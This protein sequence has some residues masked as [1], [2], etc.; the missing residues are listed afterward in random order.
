MSD[1]DKE[2]QAPSHQT[3]AA[4]K[5][6]LS[7]TVGLGGS[8]PMTATRTPLGPASLVFPA[9]DPD[10]DRDVL[11]SDGKTIRKKRSALIYPSASLAA[12]SNQQPFSRSAA[13]RES[14]LALGSIGYLQH[15][16]TK[17]GIANRNRPVAKGMMALAIGPAG[18]A[19]LANKA[20]TA[21]GSTSPPDPIRHARSTSAS[22]QI[23][24]D[25][26]E[27]ENFELPPSPTA[28]TYARPKYLDVARPLEA[29]TKALRALLIADLHQLC[30]AWALWDWISHDPTVASIKLLL[31]EGQPTPSSS[32]VAEESA[33][34]EVPAIIAVTTKAIRS[35]RSYVLALPQRSTVPATAPNQPNGRDMYRRQ[36]GFSG[37]CRPGQTGTPVTTRTSEFSHNGPTARDASAQQASRS[38]ALSQSLPGGPASNVRAQDDTEHLSILRKAALEILSALKAMEERHRAELEDER[39]QQDGAASICPAREEDQHPSSSNDAEESSAVDTASE[40]GYSYRP[41]LQLSDLATERKLLQGY[42]KTVSSILTSSNTGIQE[43]KKDCRRLSNSTST[44]ANDNRK[45]TEDVQRTTAAVDSTLLNSGERPA[46][47]ADIGRRWTKINLCTAQRILSFVVDHC[48]SCVGQDFSE[49]RL[50]RLHDAGDDLDRLLVLLHDGYL[51]CRALNEVVRRSDR[52]W[53]YI[54]SSEIHDLEAEEAALRQKEALRVRQEQESDAPKFQTRTSSRT[55]SEGDSVTA[56]VGG[57]SNPSES[58]IFNGRPGWTFRRTENLRVWAAALKLRYQIQTTATKAFASKPTSTDPTYGSLGLGKLA[59]HGRRVASESHAST[60]S[61]ESRTRSAHGTSKTIDFDPAKVARK[62]D[63]WQEMLT[64]LLIAWIDAVTEGQAN[65]TEIA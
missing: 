60:L 16:Y 6:P 21:A 19:M 8:S 36:S 7:T 35:V 15:L 48:E 39:G 42:L 65:D 54:S 47:Y 34:A 22:S 20:N 33:A 55:D 25:D 40:A 52:P 18:E 53:G 44:D 5:R 11:A 46:D 43:R 9:E 2:N 38:A 4:S 31:S 30:I 32:K 28:G 26:E 63:D 61:S 1:P 24:E 58:G 13:K 45:S 14:I 12:K 3:V 29:D 41:D 64:T 51:L 59:L 56:E 50:D 49:S 57:S 10:E 27:I 23:A 17:Q 37:V 62:E